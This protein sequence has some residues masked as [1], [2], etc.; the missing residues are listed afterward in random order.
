MECWGWF[1]AKNARG[2]GVIGL[3]SKLILASHASYMIHHGPI[4]AGLVVRHRCDNPSC[5]NPQHLEI[6]TLSD[7]SRDMVRR[8]RAY[9]SKLGPDKVSEIRCM[10]STGEYTQCELAEMYGV[11][12]VTVGNITAG[13]CWHQ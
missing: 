5:N 11:T 3:D 10:Y 4:T 12:R 13:K 1:G 7:N 2:Y 6:G 9:L 8:G